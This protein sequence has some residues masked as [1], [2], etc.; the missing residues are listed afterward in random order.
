MIESYFHNVPNYLSSW[1][2]VPTKGE[3]EESTSRWSKWSPVFTTPTGRP[4]QVR[5]NLNSHLVE[6]SEEAI[7]L[8]GTPLK[9]V[10]NYMK[11]VL[12]DNSV[13]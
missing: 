11:A 4:F 7:V 10:T 12:N 1:K 2:S 3:K 5:V 9:Q 6:F 13:S 8:D